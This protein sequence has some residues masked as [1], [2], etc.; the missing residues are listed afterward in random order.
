MIS[1]T[2]SDISSQIA[3]VLWTADGTTTGGTSTTDGITTTDGY[4][5]TDG[6]FNPGTKSQVST[7]TISALKLVELKSSASSHT[8]TCKITVGSMD[9]QVVP[10][11]SQTIT[12]FNPSE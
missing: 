2:L 7:L 6:S 4:T 9:P 1:C 11:D 12:I 10:S 8:F 3:G 5:V